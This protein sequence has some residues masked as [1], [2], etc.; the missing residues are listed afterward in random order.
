MLLTR[1]PGICPDVDQTGEWPARADSMIA[2]SSDRGA[3]FGAC[4]RLFSGYPL[5]VVA[6]FDGS[7]SRSVVLMRSAAGATAFFVLT[8][9]CDDLFVLRSWS[10][11]DGISQ[12][13]RPGEPVPDLISGILA[14]AMPFPRGR[15]L[16]GW[17]NDRQVT[18]VLAVHS[19]QLATQE[20]PEMYVMPESGTRELDWPP[21]TASPLRDG[22]LWDHVERGQIVDI[23]PLLTQNAGRAFWVP[24]P[25]GRSAGCVV[26]QGNLPAEEY[27]LPAG[28]YVDHWMLREGIQAPPSGHLMARP[29]TVDL[30]H[31][32][33]GA[34]G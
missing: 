25:Y 16:L 20:V 5:A 34:E 15:R 10:C 4:S 22:R 6:H 33:Q 31:A 8:Q 32:W 2:S 28:V 3:S 27:W 26:V 24:G 9:A 12:E 29:G 21:F 7:E 23:V 17:V 11:H 1:G 14:E 19:G 30:A 13:I 18:A